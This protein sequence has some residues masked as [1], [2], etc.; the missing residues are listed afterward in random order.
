MLWREVGSFETVRKLSSVCSGDGK[1]QKLRKIDFT[2]FGTLRFQNFRLCITRKVSIFSRL[3]R[4]SV[5]GLH[6]LTCFASPE[7]TAFRWRGAGEK[8]EA[9]PEGQ[10]PSAQQ[11][12][13]PRQSP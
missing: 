4:L 12:A 6:A 1:A 7:G 9:G 2:H 3:L 13:K 8:V 10:S 11:M 5:A